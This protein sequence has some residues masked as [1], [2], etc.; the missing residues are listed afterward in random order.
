MDVP[1][2]GFVDDELGQRL[3]IAQQGVDQ[4]DRLLEIGV[5]QGADAITNPSHLVEVGVAVGHTTGPRPTGHMGQ[6][7]VHGGQSLVGLRRRLGVDE[8]GR[9]LQ[10]DFSVRSKDQLDS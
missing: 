2:E 9:P 4:L 7:V 10:G 3:A 8:G 5:P 1:A 6:Q